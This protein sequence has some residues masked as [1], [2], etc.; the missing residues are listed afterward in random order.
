MCS[1]ALRISGAVLAFRDNPKMPL[2]SLA[3]PGHIDYS[4]T[5]EFLALLAF[6]CCQD[7]LLRHPQQWLRIALLHIVVC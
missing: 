1:Q 3:W 7:K 4:Q 2:T 5:V 6:N